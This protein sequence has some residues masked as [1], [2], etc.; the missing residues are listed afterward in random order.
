V[1]T[2][3]LDCLDLAGTW[4]SLSPS[5]PL[6]GPTAGVSRRLCYIYIHRRASKN[7]SGF[8]NFLF[9]LRSFS[10]ASDFQWEKY[11][12]NTRHVYAEVGCDTPGT[13]H[14]CVCVCVRACVRNTDRLEIHVVLYVVYLFMVYVITSVVQVLLR[15]MIGWL[16]NNKFE[17]MKREVVSPNLRH[18]HGIWRGWE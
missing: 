6:P 11:R 2:W 10:A 4:P 16:S 8:K 5:V 13:P 18:C 1:V 7:L 14:I 15:R 9:N 3:V 17:R 12:N